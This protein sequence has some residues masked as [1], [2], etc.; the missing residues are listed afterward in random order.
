MI[1]QTF[2]YD[3]PLTQPWKA[4]SYQPMLQV[5]QGQLQHLHPM[6]NI[7]KQLVYS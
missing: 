6:T 2:G 5:E 4:M 3:L 1:A 7:Y